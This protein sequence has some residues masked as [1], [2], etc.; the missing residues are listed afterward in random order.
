MDQ[1]K[2][3]I[4]FIGGFAPQQ[5][6]TFSFIQPAGT[7]SGTFD[8]VVING[9]APGFQ[10]QL[11]QSSTRGL[12]LVATSN[13]V[14]ASPSSLSITSNANQLQVSWPGTATG[15]LLQ[16]STNL[17]STNWTTLDVP[18]HL[19]NLFPTN[20]AGFFRLMKP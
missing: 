9:L 12:S 10:Y 15:Y 5:G 16:S 20:A 8:Q 17:D 19:L 1:G 6:Q 7:I 2:L 13:G 18:T 11:A 3:T 14:S 4:D